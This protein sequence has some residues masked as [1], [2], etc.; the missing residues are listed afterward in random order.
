MWEFNF[1]TKT[2]FWILRKQKKQADGVMERRGELKRGERSY[3]RD[4]VCGMTTA[5]P[6]ITLASFSTSLY[7]TLLSLLLLTSGPVNAQNFSNHRPFSQL[8]CASH[9]KYRTLL[10]FQNELWH[11][12]TPPNYAWDHT[13][14]KGHGWVAAGELEN[15]VSYL[16]W[17]KQKEKEKGR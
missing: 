13:V 9:D 8:L 15:T 2:W 17:N 4:G 1:R 7:Q 10:P 6:P 3:F 11:T 12:C 16:C 5:L 14:Y